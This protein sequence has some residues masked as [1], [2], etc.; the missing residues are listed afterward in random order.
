MI[1][2]YIKRKDMKIL[3]SEDQMNRVK[4][5]LKE[6]RDHRQTYQLNC[7]INLDYYQLKYKG[8]ELNDIFPPDS[9]DVKYNIDLDIRNYGIKDV[10]VY[11]FKGPSEIEVEISYYPGTDDPT[12]D[13]LILPL[14]W[15]SAETETNNDIGYIGI[16]RDITIVL[17]ND[18][19]GNIVVEKILIS[20]YSL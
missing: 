12:E 20:R 2:I 16:D 10:S 15:E 9:I 1:N 8:Y 11:N 3:I 6:Q 4:K 14:H 18:E 17:K 19:A 5:S 7:L 13:T